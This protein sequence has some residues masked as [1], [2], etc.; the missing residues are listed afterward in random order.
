MTGPEEFYDALAAEYHLLFPDWWA[1]AQWHGE[2]IAR[3][4]A[5]RG[6]R[7]PAT[8]L[9]CTCGVGTQALPLAA[10]GYRTTGTDLSRR[11]VER[12]RR[13]AETRGLA[14]TL[15]CADV[16]DVRTA[17]T[18]TFEAVVS[19]DNALPHLLT[20]P[21][22]ERA[23]DGIRACLDDGGVLVA[24]IRDYDDLRRTRPAGVP[25]ALHGAPGSR[26]GAGQSWRWSADAEHLD[27]TLFTFR[28]R[29]AGTWAVSAHETRYR[30]LRRDRLSDVLTHRGF[31][32]AEWLLPEQSGYHQPL[33]VAVADRRGA[34]AE[35]PLR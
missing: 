16:R 27:I 25:I 17:V 20:D 24:S 26:H 32:S 10:L 29:A 11:A 15:A 33:V 19:C 5:A 31:A 18:G 35:Q 6:V 23:V 7:P 8:V 3:V 21:D 28:E 30:A 34:A 22:L 13:E 9:D 12:A 1:A 14:V 4:L 2:V